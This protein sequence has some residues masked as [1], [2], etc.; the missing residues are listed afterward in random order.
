[1]QVPAILPAIMVITRPQARKA[2]NHILDVVFEQGDGTPLK[3]SLIDDAIDDIFSLVSI[4]SDTINDLT[5]ASPTDPKQR[6]PVVKGAKSLIRLFQEYV[7]H[8]NQGGNPI[9]DWL[10]VTQQSFD[11]FRASPA[12]IKVVK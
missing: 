5:Y 12:A 11:E 7:I 8:C 4:D 2:F 10:Q 3:S 9:N 1:M 6:L